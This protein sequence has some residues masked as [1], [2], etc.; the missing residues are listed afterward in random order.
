M[1]RIIN[2]LFASVCFLGLFSCGEDASEKPIKYEEFYKN[3]KIKSKLEG[4]F[5]VYKDGGADTVVDKAIFYHPNG[6][7]KRIITKPKDQEPVTFAY[8]SKEDILDDTW[9]GPGCFL[10]QWNQEGM[11]VGHWLLNKGQ[12]FCKIEYYEKDPGEVKNYLILVEGER[13]EG[14]W[15]DWKENKEIFNEFFESDEFKKLSKDTGI[16]EKTEISALEALE[17]H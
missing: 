3:G 8:A 1:R 2:T 17:N 10:L 16:N 9:L 6:K 13:K 5:V 4:R 15:L 11:R 12:N 14:T 7:L